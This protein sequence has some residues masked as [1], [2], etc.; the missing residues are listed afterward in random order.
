MTNAH[1]NLIV[2]NLHLPVKMAKYFAATSGW[3]FKSLIDFEDIVSVGNLGLIDAARKYD[4]DKVKSSFEAYAMIRIKGSVYDFIRQV[5]WAPKGAVDDYKETGEPLKT[6]T[7][8]GLITSEDPDGTVR[9]TDQRSRCRGNLVDYK[10]SD[11]KSEICK[12]DNE[13]AIKYM[14]RHLTKIERGI[15]DNYYIKHKTLKE[16]GKQLG[17]SEAS[18]CIKMKKIKRKSMERMESFSKR[19]L[20]NFLSNIR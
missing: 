10:N 9:N 19:D 1:D 20:D 6:I 7:S 13:D 11:S 8:I 12:I 14:I 5:S 3:P 15:V 16:I 17:L 2:E 18:I 4:P